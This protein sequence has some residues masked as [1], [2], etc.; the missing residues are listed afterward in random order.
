MRMILGLDHPTAGTG[1]DRGPVRIVQHPSTPCS[2]GGRAAGRQVPSRKGRTAHNNLLAL[3]ADRTASRVSGSTQVLELVGLTE[4]VAS[5]VAPPRSPSAWASGL[6]I[7]AALLGDPA[8]PLFDEPVNGLRHRGDRVDPQ[9]HA[10]AR[11]RQGR[12]RSWSPPHLMS[13][14]ALTAGPRHR[15]RPRRRLIAATTS[16]EEFVARSSNNY[17]RVR[18]DDERPRALLRGRALRRARPRT[19]P[20]TCG[21]WTSKPSG[22]WPAAHGIALHE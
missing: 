20:C 16:M 13:E 10:L 17:V 21:G 15:G 3:G 14:M 22:I 18:S 12:G 8:V 1:D 6:G 11:R 19:A 5:T 2:A 4:S 7:A 9:L